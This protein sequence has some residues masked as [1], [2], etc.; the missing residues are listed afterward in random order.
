M[1]LNLNTVY[2]VL[3]KSLFL[4]LKMYQSDIVNKKLAFFKEKAMPNMLHLNKQN[5]RFIYCILSEKFP[6]T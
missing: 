5:K 1:K 6:F 2:L 4:F 3:L